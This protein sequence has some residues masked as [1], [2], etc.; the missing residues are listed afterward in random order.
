MSS[1]DDVLI[2]VLL[3]LLS[4]ESALRK[5]TSRLAVRM[6]YLLDPFLLFFDFVDCTDADYSFLMEFLISNET[7]FLEYLLKFCKR[8]SSNWSPTKGTRDQVNRVMSILI[9][10]RIHIQELHSKGLFPYSPKALLKAI[11]AMEFCYDKKEISNDVT[12]FDEDYVN[13]VKRK[14]AQKEQQKEVER[15]QRESRK[16]N[17]PKKM[18]I[19]S[20]FL[21]DIKVWN[22]SLESPFKSDWNFDISLHWKVTG[23]SDPKMHQFLCPSILMTFLSDSISLSPSLSHC[24]SLPLRRRKSVKHDARKSAERG[25]KYWPREHAKNPNS[26]P[27]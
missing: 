1:E 5:S 16:S 8:M 10:L 3:E 9:R 15:Q 24:P 17:R 2:E 22:E 14:E 7:L 18:N 11:E 23:N 13:Y 26:M 6:R 27:S 12:M 4:I 25:K 20:L 21:Q 19:N